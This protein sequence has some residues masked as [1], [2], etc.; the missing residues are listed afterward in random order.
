MYVLSSAAERCLMSAQAFL[1]GFL[2]PEKSVLPI[3]WQPVAVNSLPRDR[4]NVRIHISL[5]NTSR[6]WTHLHLNLFAV[7]STENGLPKV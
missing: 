2:V 3:S 6:T 7:V 5:S 4:D 1:A